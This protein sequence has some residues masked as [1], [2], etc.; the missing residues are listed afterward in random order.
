MGDTMK[1]FRT[2]RFIKRTEATEQREPTILDH[3]DPITVRLTREIEERKRRL[4][5]G[6]SHPMGL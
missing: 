2:I 4:N 6:A 1:R 5:L 3:G